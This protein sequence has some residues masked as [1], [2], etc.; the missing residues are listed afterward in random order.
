MRAFVRLVYLFLC[1][2]LA[3]P[4]ISIANKQEEEK[5][6]KQNY[7]YEGTVHAVNRTEKESGSVI[8]IELNANVIQF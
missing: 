6:K 2:C 4:S 7:N 5:K 8:K 1:M 3:V